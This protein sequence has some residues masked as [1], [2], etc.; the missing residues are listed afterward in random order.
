MF[1]YFFF[2]LGLVLFYDELILIPKT[3][4]DEFHFVPF[5]LFAAIIFKIVYMPLYA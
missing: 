5:L 3:I 2:F 1:I 4:A